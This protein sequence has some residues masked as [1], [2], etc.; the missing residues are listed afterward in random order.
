MDHKEILEKLKDN[1]LL[2][3]QYEMIKEFEEKSEQP[4]QEKSANQA[5]SSTEKNMNK[6]APNISLTKNV[7]KLVN[8]APEIRLNNNQSASP[9]Y[10]R[11]KSTTNTLVIPPLPSVQ[12]LIDQHKTSKVDETKLN[13]ESDINNNTKKSFAQQISQERGVSGQH[14]GNSRSM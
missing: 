9:Q 11:T 4:E 7:Q 8:N 5:K 12:K 6:K 13:H 14:E 3:A 2:N 1:F 10:P